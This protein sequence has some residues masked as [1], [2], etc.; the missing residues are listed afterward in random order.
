MVRDEELRFGKI[1][2]LLWKFGFPAVVGVVTAGIQEIIDGFFIGNVIGSKGLAGITLAYP[3]YVAIIAI[4]VLIGIGSSSLIALELGR[5]NTKEALDIAHNVFPLCLLAGAIVTIG[6]LVFCETSINLLETS[7]SAITFALEYLRI[8]FIGSIF[9]IISLALDPLVRSD[10][11]PKLC[12]NIM[13]AALVAHVVFNYLLVM[14]MGMGMS[15]AAV[16]TVISFALPAVLLML[17]LFG[18]E[19][20]LK[21]RLKAMRF[22]I[23]TL[24][25]ILK[26]GF[27]SFVMQLSLAFVLFANNYMLLDTVQSLQSPLMKL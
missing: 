15:G 2:N 8:I 12:M 18:K 7:E 6:G 27:P 23:G 20:K 19:A 26:A 25:Q 17:Y 22:K 10:G 4:G 5:G 13:I 11:K 9:M 1:F 24:I 14:R 3:L 16:A 21:L